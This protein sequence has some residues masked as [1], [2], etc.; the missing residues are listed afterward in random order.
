M[1]I[2]WAIVC[3]LFKC[4]FTVQTDLLH[5]CGT[6]LPSGPPVH[7]F[8]KKYK[9]SVSVYASEHKLNNLTEHNINILGKKQQQRYSNNV[10]TTCDHS[11]CKGGP[12]SSA[13]RLAVINVVYR[14]YPFLFCPCKLYLHDIMVM[15]A[16]SLELIC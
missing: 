2:V 13:F 15:N 14:A 7:T 10:T 12:A 8:G 6:H 1:P 11:R 3:L 16:S 5:M 9:H 4:L